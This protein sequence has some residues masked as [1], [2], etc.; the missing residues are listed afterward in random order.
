MAIKISVVG[1]FT[2]KIR[3]HTRKDLTDELGENIEVFEKI[4]Y[5]GKDYAILADEDGFL[6]ELP[7]NQYVFNKFGLYIQGAALLVDQRELKIKE[8]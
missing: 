7:V 1:D 5:G 3:V 8:K 6:K 4:T 2:Y